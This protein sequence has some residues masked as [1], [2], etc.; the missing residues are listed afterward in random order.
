MTE[1]LFE[2]MEEEYGGKWDF[3]PD[4]IVAAQKMIAHIDE[5]RKALGLD[6]SRERVLY[7]ME[8]RRQLDAV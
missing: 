2:G 8:M 6:K 4:P 5:K 1:Y 7:D 3:E